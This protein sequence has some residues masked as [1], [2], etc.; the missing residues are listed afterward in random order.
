MVRWRWRK[1]KKINKLQSQRLQ[2]FVLTG[3]KWVKIIVWI[4]SH[5][6]GNSCSCLLLALGMVTFQWPSP[7]LR[8]WKFTI[9]WPR[10]RSLLQLWYVAVRSSWLQPRVFQVDYSVCFLCVELKGKVLRSFPL[11]WSFWGNCRRLALLAHP[12]NGS[13]YLGAC[14]SQIPSA[15]V[16]SKLLD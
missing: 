12:I 6:I 13:L 9:Q 8:F 16:V 14:V 7:L 1:K 3:T 15:E 2:I 10:T 4:A 11:H 5:D